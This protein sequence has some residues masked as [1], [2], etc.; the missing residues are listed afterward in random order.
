M[1]KAYV[2][3]FVPQILSKL[4]YRLVHSF[5]LGTWNSNWL[6]SCHC[7]L[8]VAVK[9]SDIT[10]P[11]PCPISRAAGIEFSGAVWA[12][13]RN[14]GLW[15]EFSRII[16]PWT[17][18]TQAMFKRFKASSQS[19]KKR[20]LQAQTMG[21]QVWWG[22]NLTPLSFNEPHGLYP[23]KQAMEKKHVQ[24][25]SKEE[26]GLSENMVYSQL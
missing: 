11:R 14:I 10:R 25:C 2:R 7:G 23:P 9:S 18:V 5:I 17:T 16:S 15:A 19:H 13:C 21:P 24:T 6:I 4:W 22:R 8:P 3:G 1:Y 20:F 26:M 12:R